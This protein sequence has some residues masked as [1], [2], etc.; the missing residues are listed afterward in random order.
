MT[1][2]VS[3]TPIHTACGGA[4]G[5][6]FQIRGRRRAADA[7]KPDPMHVAEIVF[8]LFQR[9]RRG[10]NERGAFAIDCDFEGVARALADDALHVLEI[11]D[12][13]AVDGNDQIAGLKSGG[14]GRAVGLHRV[15]PG[16]HRLLAVQS[17]DRCKNDDSQNEIRHRSGDDYGGA[18]GYRLEEKALLAFV[19]GHALQTRSIR[20]ASGVLI[21]EE[22]YVA[23][24]RNGGDFPARAVTIV[25]PDDF[26]AETDGKHQNSDATQPGDQEMA[27]LVE[28]HHKA[29]DE[30][31]RDEIGG[32][33]AP[34][35]MQMRQQIRP[36]NACLTPPVCPVPN[37]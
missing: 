9:R 27:K 32:N 35:R 12:G 7:K 4:T 18:L 34:Q 22:L 25:K 21:A 23:A 29:E 5:W 28:E 10:K 3:C 36:H 30:Q 26:R 6:Q 14:G 15:H 16:S 1:N 24:E 31:E 19:F 37:P 8:D 33:A 2:Q 17:E 11:V 20:G 13:L